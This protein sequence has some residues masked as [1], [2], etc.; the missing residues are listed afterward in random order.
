MSLITTRPRVLA[1]GVACAA[2]GAGAGTVAAAGAST[3]HRSPSGA[4]AAH[5][6]HAR[7]LIR[8]LRR[9]VHGELTIHTAKGF[10]TVTMNRGT[11]D[12]VSGDSLTMT[13]GTP[14]ASDQKVTLTIPAGARIRNERK[15]A[16]LSSLT[17]GERVVV[18][19]LPRR[20]IVRAHPAH[21]RTT[22]S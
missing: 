22:A 11:V 19:Q 5:V 3:G 20:T 21:S 16:T 12:A 6:G 8:L 13:D 10:R 4:H 15:P 18:V 9:S 17:A 1:L 7:G 14:K 2:A